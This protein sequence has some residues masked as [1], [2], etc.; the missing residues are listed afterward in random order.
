M[1]LRLYLLKGIIKNYCPRPFL[2]TGVP[3]LFPDEPEL[4]GDELEGE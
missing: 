3:P 2:C 1:N 4:D